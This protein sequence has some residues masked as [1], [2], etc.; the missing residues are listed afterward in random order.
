MKIREI[1][2]NDRLEWVRLRDALWPG[3]LWDHD[4]ETRRYF[5]TRADRPIVFVADAGGRLVGIL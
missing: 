2:E 1:T 5:E 4:V 3:S